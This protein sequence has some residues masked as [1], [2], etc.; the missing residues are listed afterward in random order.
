MYTV[1][2]VLSG[3]TAVNLFSIVSSEAAFIAPLETEA[4]ATQLTIQNKGSAAIEVISVPRSAS[5]AN[6]AAQG[7]IDVAASGGSFSIDN[8]SE[9]AI[10]LKRIWL[11]AVTSVGTSIGISWLPR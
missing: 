5:A 1:A 8:Q 6:A 4:L 11:Q 7:G 9:R 10:D 3:T 2:F